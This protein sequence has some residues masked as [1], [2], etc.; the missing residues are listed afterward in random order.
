MKYFVYIVLQILQQYINALSIYLIDLFDDNFTFKE[1]IKGKQWSTIVQ[2][3]IINISQHSQL[4]TA[5]RG[6]Y[7][8]V[9]KNESRSRNILSTYSLRHSYARG[10]LQWLVFQQWTPKSAR[11]VLR[12]ETIYFPEVSTKIGHGVYAIFVQNLD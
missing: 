1:I 10:P 9:T 7:E 6:C 3:L 8:T 4:A 11:R 5:L 2:K 12:T